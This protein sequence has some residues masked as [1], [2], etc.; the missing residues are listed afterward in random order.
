MLRGGD[1]MMN[2]REFAQDI[3][4][5]LNDLFLHMIEE[6]SSDRLKHEIIGILDKVEKRAHGIWPVK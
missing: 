5:D 1:G 3:L 2:E 6:R 4:D